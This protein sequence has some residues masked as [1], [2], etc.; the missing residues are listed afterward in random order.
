MQTLNKSLQMLR[1]DGKIHW[2]TNCSALLQHVQMDDPIE[3]IWE[4]EQ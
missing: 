1:G 2:Q 3:T 4:M